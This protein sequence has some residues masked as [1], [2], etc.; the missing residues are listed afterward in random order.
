MISAKEAN[1]ASIEAESLIYI[2]DKKKQ[3]KLQL[4]KL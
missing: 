1:K 3:L 2:E 4:I